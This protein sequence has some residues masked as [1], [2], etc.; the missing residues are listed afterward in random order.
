MTETPESGA[1]TSDN[2]PNPFSLFGLHEKLVWGVEDLGFTQP[3]EIQ[4]K[5]IPILL[6]GRDMVA[7]ARTGTGKTAAFG[8]PTLNRLAP[9]KS[10]SRY[11]RALILTPTRELCMQ[12]QTSLTDFGRYLPLKTVAVL[13]GMG[14]AAQ[15][16]DLKKGADIVAATPGRLLDLAEQRAIMFDD[17]EVLI[18]DEAD[19][20]LDMGFI[21]DV[22]RIIS[23]LPENRQSMMFSATMPPVIR[24]LAKQFLKDP[25]YL[26][27]ARHG[28]RAETVEHSL[29]PVKPHLK[30]GLLLKILEQYGHDGTFIIFTRTRNRTNEVFRAIEVK[31]YKVAKLHSDCSQKERN[32]ALDAFREK[33]IN[34]LVATDVASRGLDVEGISHVI[35]YDVPTQAEDYVHRI[36]RTGRAFSTGEAFT[37]C[38][39]SEESLLRAVEM[40]LNEKIPV[41]IQDGFNY[42]APPPPGFWD[43]LPVVGGGVS[44]VTKTFRPRR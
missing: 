8:L 41:R 40:L 6:Q 3:T 12:I 20:M 19:R 24:E 36:G 13:G 18:L 17:V 33:R 9:G 22:K 30:K 31:G 11:P 34:I 15:I 5:S 35:N 21:P 37:L 29:W 28:E 2:S 39:P 1:A 10:R 32:E 25:E 43:D 26:D 23:K 16:S 4:Q 44:G 27:V 14:M 38:Q 7:C 42:D